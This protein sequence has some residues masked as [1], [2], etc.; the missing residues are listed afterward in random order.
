MQPSGNAEQSELKP[1]VSRPE[2]S[3]GKEQ[4]I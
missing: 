4:I 2:A 1:T 3:I